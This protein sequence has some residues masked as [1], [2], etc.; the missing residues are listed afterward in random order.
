MSRIHDALKK[1]E[2]EKAAGVVPATAGENT[3][4]QTGEVNKRSSALLAPAPAGSPSPQGSP[5]GAELGKTLLEKTSRPSWNPNR[6]TMLLF[7]RRRIV[8]GLEEF[9]ILRSHL[10]LI[11]ERHPSR[12]LLV[13]SPLPKEGKTFVAANLA[14]VIARQAERRVLL[15]DADLRA[16]TMH[17]VLGAPPSP[18]LTDYLAGSADLFSII[19]RGPVE[20]F[21]FIPSGKVVG[22]PSELI[23][24]GRMKNLLRILEPAFDSIIIDSPPALPVADT[25][26]LGE[27]CDGVLLVVLAGSTLFTLAQKALQQFPEERRLG[28]VINRAETSSIYGS[29]YY[30]H[31]YKAD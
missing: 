9:R 4:L 29:N 14:Q 15:V 24:S 27:L 23:G 21:F 19:Q 11:G 6:K 26:L 3:L 8:V 20:N 25:K 5:E 18:G 22:N 17:R 1:A 12:K 10:D 31:A 2:E 16:S 30:E 28:V 7:D 13:T